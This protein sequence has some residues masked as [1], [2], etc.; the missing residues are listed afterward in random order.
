MAWKRYLVLIENAQVFRRAG[1]MTQYLVYLIAILT[2]LFSILYT[3]AKT[4]DDDDCT[5]ESDLLDTCLLVM[6]H[7]DLNRQCFR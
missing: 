7:P 2:T 6:R 3:L 4:D 5:V 1:H